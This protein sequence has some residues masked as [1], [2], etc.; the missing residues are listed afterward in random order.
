MGKLERIKKTITEFIYYPEHDKRHETEEYRKNR[1]I[2]TKQYGCYICGS[3][4]NLETHHYGCEWAEWNSTNPEKLKEFLLEF[5]IYGYSKKYKDKPITSPDD[6]R[7][8]MVL[9]Q[10][11]HRHKF[12]G[13]HNMTFPIWI[14]QRI[15]K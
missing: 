6:I 1:E 3:K 9:C 4:E 11:H 5:D 8:L 7:N 12:Y 14:M 2:L 15:K 10:K 13:I